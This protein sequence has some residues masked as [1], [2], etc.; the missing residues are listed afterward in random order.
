MRVRLR[1]A[2]GVR[3]VRRA[4]AGLAAVA[5]FVVAPAPGAEAASPRLSEA[6]TIGVHN[7]YQKDTYTYFANAL[8]SGASLLEI[9]IYADSVNR[10][11]RVS[12][13][14]PLGDDNNCEYADTPGELYG[15]DRNQDF[16]SC[17]DNIAAW[18]QLHPDHAPIVFKIEMKVG[19]N[20]DAGLGPDELDALIASKLG[21]LVYK[22]SDLLGSTYSTLDAA[23]QA[24]AW[25]S[26]SALTGKFLF[27]VIPGTV[28]KS[29]PTD[30]LWTDEEYADYLRDLYAAGNLSKAQMFPAVLDAAAGDPRTRYSDTS[31]RPWFVVFDGDAATYINNG[32]DTAWYDDRHYLLIMTDAENVSPAI[33]ATSPTDQE[34]ADRLALL[35]KDGASVITADWSSK[36]ASVLGEV[37]TRG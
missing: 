5:A 14:N 3:G 28:E 33:S 2:G 34:V 27:E 36:S 12:H 30:S 4:L 31:I 23:A 7:A 25:P 21:N 10:R 26:R 18:Q 37:A 13:S 1:G 24:N 8:D 9:D 16:G 19:F 20:N 29:N 32:Y 17:L 22:P 35:A 15:Q 11:W 6:T